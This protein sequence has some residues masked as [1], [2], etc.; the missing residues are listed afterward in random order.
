MSSLD[1]LDEEPLAGLVREHAT[2]TGSPLA[3]AL[4]TDWDRARTGFRKVAPRESVVPVA[5]QTAR[6]AGAAG[7]A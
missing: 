7:K 1:A 4:L 5:P 6:L 3:R 2:R